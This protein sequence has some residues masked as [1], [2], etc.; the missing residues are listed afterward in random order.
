[1]N[2]QEW[3]ERVGS[4]E[5]SP[6]RPFAVGECPV[7]GKEEQL[8]PVCGLSLDG[9]AS[10]VRRDELHPPVGWA[11][12]PIVGFETRFHG[13]RVSNITFRT[14]PAGFTRGSMLVN[15]SD[16]ELWMKNL[17]NLSG[18]IDFAGERVAVMNLW[19]DF[20]FK[21]VRN[22]HPVYQS[23]TGDEDE[24][25][26]FTADI[27]VCGMELSARPPTAAGCVVDV[28]NYGPV[29]PAELPCEVP[30]NFR[31]FD[32]LYT[33]QLLRGEA[34]PP[35]GEQFSWLCEKFF[36]QHGKP[37][38]LTRLLEQGAG[39]SED[40]LREHTEAGHGFLGM[41]KIEQERF[42]VTASIP[43][44]EIRTGNFERPATTS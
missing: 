2:E 10:K 41:L 3:K 38:A 23:P 5:A 4:L 44:L 21:A 7:T 22:I 28:P 40:R 24:W 37:T 33:Q 1:M 9:M 32:Y 29:G 16:D 30:V 36:G 14:L 43:Q 19:R 39:L 26:G 17:D 18:D 15:F 6:Y 11:L 34:V 31:D 20:L 25:Y 27:L 8:D 42:G 12:N 35:P 13:K